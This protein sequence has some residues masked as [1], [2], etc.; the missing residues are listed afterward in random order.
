MLKVGPSRLGR[1][2]RRAGPAHSHSAHLNQD[3]KTNDQNNCP[4]HPFVADHRRSTDRHSACLNGVRKRRPSR[5]PQHPQHTP[6]RKGNRI[7]TAFGSGSTRHIPWMRQA[8]SCSIYS[9][10]VPRTGPKSGCGGLTVRVWLSGNAD[11][12]DD[13]SRV[14]RLHVVAGNQSEQAGNTTPAR[15]P[16]GCTNDENGHRHR[17]SP[18]RGPQPFQPSLTQRGSASEGA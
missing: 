13:Y 6:G 11:D 9:T 8:G 3:G 1:G 10:L 2:P 7:L 18:N 16:H 5:R 4:A 12:L 15:S 14:D 17:R